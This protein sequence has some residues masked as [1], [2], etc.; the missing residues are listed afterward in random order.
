MK[1]KKDELNTS[2][3]QKIYTKDDYSNSMLEISKKTALNTKGLF[4]SLSSKPTRTRAIKAKCIDCMGFERYSVRI[5][6]CSTTLCPLWIF[7]PYQ[8]INKKSLTEE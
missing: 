4:N 2:N 6:N 1:T 3:D 5:H 7:R 8:R